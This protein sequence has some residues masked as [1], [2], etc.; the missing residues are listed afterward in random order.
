M[1]CMIMFQ[2]MHPLCNIQ[3]RGMVFLMLLQPSDA[4]Y[5][6][7]KMKCGIKMTKNHYID[8]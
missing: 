8:A 6:T 5:K 4:T 1:N 7:Y 2:Y 3:I